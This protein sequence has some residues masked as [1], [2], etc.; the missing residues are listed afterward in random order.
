MDY[1]TENLFQCFRGA[2]H[3]KCMRISDPTQNLVLSLETLKTV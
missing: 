2:L 3:L 1:K